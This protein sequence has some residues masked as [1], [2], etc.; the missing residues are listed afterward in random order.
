MLVTI[1]TTALK[2]FP[3]Y[4]EVFLTGASTVD[5]YQKITVDNLSDLLCI[6]DKHGQLVL[7]RSTAYD[8]DAAF[9]I[10][11]YDDYRE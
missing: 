10:E 4:G 2:T 9:H 8:K 6:L 7:S 1:N 11:V 5:K 3:E